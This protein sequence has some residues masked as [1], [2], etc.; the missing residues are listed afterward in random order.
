MLLPCLQIWAFALLEEMR[1]SHTSYQDRFLGHRH[2]F[3]GPHLV[4]EDAEAT[5]HGGT[6]QRTLQATCNAPDLLKHPSPLPRIINPPYHQPSEK[7][8]S[9]K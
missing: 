1:G 8:S 6:G 2:G 9:P 5:H 3:L 7:Y 4:K